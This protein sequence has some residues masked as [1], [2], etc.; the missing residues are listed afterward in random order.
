[1]AVIPSVRQR[2]CPLCGTRESRLLLE[3]SPWRLVR[4][5][6]CELAYLPEV[7]SDQAIDTTYEWSESFARARYE[8]WSRNGGK[9][10]AARASDVWHKT[11]EEYEEPELEPGLKAELKAFVD[12]RR[13]ELG[14]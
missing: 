13:T 1:M 4:C 3:R 2:D 9:D 11:I 8:R 14:D 12:R 7:P 6:G 10:A 5:G